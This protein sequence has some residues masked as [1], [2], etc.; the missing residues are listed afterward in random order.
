MRVAIFL[1]RH[2]TG[3]FHAALEFKSYRGRARKNSTPTPAETPWPHGFQVWDAGFSR[4]VNGMK[5]W[6]ERHADDD[7]VDD[8]Y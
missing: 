2:N 1:S 7:A 8:D 4:K 6:H 5:L 3:A